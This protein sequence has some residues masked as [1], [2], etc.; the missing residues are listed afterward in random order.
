MDPAGSGYIPHRALGKRR[1]K[2][3][4][5]ILLE[6][7]GRNPLVVAV[8][9]VIVH[10]QGRPV[11]PKPVHHADL[12]T[13]ESL[14]PQKEHGVVHVFFKRLGVYVLTVCGGG[15]IERRIREGVAGYFDAS[16]FLGAVGLHYRI[17]YPIDDN[18]VME[19]IK[20][21]HS[22][23]C[24]VKGIPGKVRGSRMGMGGRHHDVS[25]VVEVPEPRRGQSLDDAQLNALKHVNHLGD[26]ND[27]RFFAA[28]APDYEGSRMEPHG[29]PF[30]VF[31]RLVVSGAGLG[32]RPGNIS[33]SDSDLILGAF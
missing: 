6:H 5:L 1:H 10:A 22:I 26:N 27:H 2:T 7:I 33:Y 9:Q 29:E 18:I 31:S 20:T 15:A 28:R 11:H 21:D 8:D 30:H 4:I 12:G 16:G 13:I 14:H 23:E 17:D 32:Q 25:L 24:I 19:L 3:A